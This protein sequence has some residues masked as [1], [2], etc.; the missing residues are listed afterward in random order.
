MIKVECSL[1][2]SCTL[3]VGPPSFSFFL[4]LDVQIGICAQICGNAKHS[5]LQANGNYILTYTIF[6]LK[7]YREIL[8]FGD[9]K[10]GMKNRGWSFFSCLQISDLERRLQ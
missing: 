5:Q 1:F 9:Y 2:L 3:L 4:P 7:K 10:F 6:S 8:D